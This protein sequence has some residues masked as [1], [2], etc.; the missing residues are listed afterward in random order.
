M[1]NLFKSVI[2]STLVF[3]TSVFANTYTVKYGDSFLGIALRHGMTQTQLQNLNPSID[4]ERL[5]AGTRLEVGNSKTVNRVNTQQPTTSNTQQKASSTQ[6]QSVNRA[7]TQQPTTSNRQQKASSTQTQSVQQ[8][9]VQNAVILERVQQVPQ[10]NQYQ[11]PV[12]QQP[13]QYQ[14][15]QVPQYQVPQYQTVPPQY[16]APIGKLVIIDG[17]TYITQPVQ[18]IR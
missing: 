5:K 11:Q 15:Y 12:V 10:Y 3:A 17:Q 7:T 13:I 6:T 18:T 16:Y 9:V 14:Q 2:I 1:K 4:I 8:Q